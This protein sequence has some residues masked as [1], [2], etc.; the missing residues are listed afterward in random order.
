MYTRYVDDID[1]VVET[2]HDDEITMKG[3]QLVANGI[4]PSIRV[5]I[6]YP[7]KHL[8]K[9]LPVLDTKQ[10]IEGGKLLHTYYSKPLSNQYVVMANSALSTRSKRNILVADL[11]RIMRCV[12]TLCD[13]SERDKHVQTFIYRMQMSG[14]GQDERVSVYKAARAKYDQQ[15][16]NDMDGTCPLYRSKQ[17]RQQRR[18]QERS[19]K[20]KTWYGEKYDAVYFVQATP[21]SQLADQ[22][23]KVFQRC[24]LKVK[25]VERTGRTIKQL[26]VKSDPM[27]KGEC[28]CRICA[29]AGKQICKVRECVYEMTCSLCHQQYI[30]ETSRSLYERYNEH[31]MLLQREDINSVFFKHT[32]QHHKEE[33]ASVTWR[34]K[35]LARC[36]GD[37][38][39]RQATEAT[40]IYNKRPVLNGRGEFHDSGR[41]RQQRVTSVA[42][43]NA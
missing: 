1:V 18:M 36:P 43:N 39:L 34:V 21:G 32:Q 38:A 6:D 25:V 31:M 16:K 27:N 30:G 14:Y 35:I 20:R 33:A 4:H 24:D 3:I 26:L 7:T 2:D 10:W 22:C 41:T 13:S 8:D 11:L 17:W 15:V 9:R 28:K 42:T 40:Y 29:M 19:T 23:Q 5:T 37:P 12:S